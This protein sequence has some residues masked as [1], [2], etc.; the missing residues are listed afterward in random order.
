MEPRKGSMRTCRL[1]IV[2][3]LLGINKH[4]ARKCETPLECFSIFI[5]DNIIY[6]NYEMHKYKNRFIFVEQ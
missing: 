4:K 6:N 2:L 3:E 1:N 5:D